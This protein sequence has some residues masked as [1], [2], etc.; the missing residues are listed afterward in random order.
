MIGT[1]WPLQSETPF[2]SNTGLGSLPNVWLGCENVILPAAVLC[3]S[4]VAYAELPCH[5]A[6]GAP[7]R[8]ARLGG[9]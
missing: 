8:V 6:V 4:R 5:V 7:V 9:V 1:G 2:R 3:G